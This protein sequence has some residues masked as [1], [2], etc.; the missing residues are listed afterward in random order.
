MFHTRI[1]IDS[2]EEEISHVEDPVINKFVRFSIIP[3]CIFLLY[4]RLS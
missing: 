4:K 3:K 1:H 2:G